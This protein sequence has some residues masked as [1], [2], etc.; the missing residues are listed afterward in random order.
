[1]FNSVEILTREIVAQNTKQSRIGPDVKGYSVGWL[2]RKCSL[3]ESGSII[4]LMLAA[5]S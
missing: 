4:T 5:V 1:M 2:L 3:R